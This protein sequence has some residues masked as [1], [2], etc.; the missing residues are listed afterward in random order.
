MARRLSEWNTKQ[1]ES[2]VLEPRWLITVGETRISTLGHTVYELRTYLQASVDLQF[3]DDWTCR[4]SIQDSRKYYQDRINQSDRMSVSM[5]YGSTGYVDGDADL[6]WSG[7]VFSR[8]VSEDVLTLVGRLGGVQL[9]PGVIANSLSGFN[10]L[11][12]HG[13]RVIM[14]DGIHQ[15][16]N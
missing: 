8:S 11:I 12:P 4:V 5:L 15:F 2:A 14:P 16:D 9:F 13:A 3:S 7:R 10:H 1:L 6:F